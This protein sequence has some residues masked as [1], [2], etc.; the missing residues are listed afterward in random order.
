MLAVIPSLL[1]LRR[2][3]M[4]AAAGPSA[5]EV[6]TYEVGTVDSQS[7]LSAR[8]TYAALFADIGAYLKTLQ[9]EDD[10]KIIIAIIALLGIA[11][12]L[13][14]AHRF[15]HPPVLELA[16]LL[17]FLSYF[18]LPEHTTTQ[19]VIGSRQIG[20]ALWFAPVFFSPMA[21]SRWHWR[22]VIVIA[23][24]VLVTRAQLGIWY[25]HLVDFQRREAF[26]LKTVLDAAPPRL[27]LSYVN[28][29]PDSYDFPWH[30]WWHVDKWYMAEKYGQVVDNPATGIMNCVRYKKRPF[31]LTANHELWPTVPD[32]WDNFDLVL[33]HHWKPTPAMI[34]AAEKRGVLLRRLGDW[35]LWQ[36]KR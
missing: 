26:G 23:G 3:F 30:A 31:S 18:F 32:I 6:A 14:R 1:L 11:V 12:T 7:I 36:A 22:R 5:G 28:L 27:R 15:R 16:A 33:V 20:I 10:L 2:W 8:K 25:R 29:A 35:E 4:R 17:S 9:S 21:A 34:A 24:I 19:A 13:S